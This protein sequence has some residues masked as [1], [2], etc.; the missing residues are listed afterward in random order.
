MIT[1][2]PRLSEILARGREP[3]DL[4]IIGAGP[5]GIS[6]A[7]E[8][9]G[10]GMRVCLLEAGGDGYDAATQSLY[11]GTVVGDRYPPLRDTRFGGLG[12]AT[13]VWAG[14]CRPLDEVDFEGSAHGRGCRW[15][16]GRPELLPYYR[17]AHEY[18]GLGFFD[19]DPDGWQSRFRQ[20]PL[21]GDDDVI[22][23]AIF[24]VL[25]R[26]FGKSF[27]ARLQASRDVE[28]VLDAPVVRLQPSENGSIRGASVQTL[29][30]R[31]LEVAA[32]R[33]VLAAGGIENARMLLL[34][35]DSPERAPGNAHG[36]VGRFFTDHPFVNLGAVTLSGSPRRLDF[37]FPQAVARAG[38]EDA[39]GEDADGEARPAVRATMTFKR[40]LIESE[41][42]QNAALFFHPR[43]E[44]HPYFASAEVKAF[45]ELWD[46]LRHKAVP[47]GLGPYLGRAMRGPH[48]IAYATARKLLVRDGPARQWRVRAMF[49]TESQH[50][51]RV[52]LDSSPD[53]LGRP[54]ARVEWRLSDYDLR[55]MRKWTQLFDARLRQAGV[56][57]LELAFENTAE[58]WRSAVEGGKHH[59]GTTRMHADPRHGVVNPN[60]RVHDSPNL[61]VT[62]SS[63]FPSGG[64][65]NPTLTIVALAI[66]LADHLRAEA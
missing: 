55:C 31:R 43:Y 5:A 28:V 39:D 58:A 33:F 66:R 42:L 40:E 49:E 3:Y 60:G 48:R 62:G 20:P 47:G 21:L 35:G 8:L 38:G 26:R 11:E 59:I 64:Y 29:D 37:Y 10:S 19:Y 57:E 25:P 56:G 1:H 50:D 23:H 13:R 65:A 16:F 34:A 4:C 18:C 44:S 46:K 2:A 12:G 24:H 15:P 7:L 51:N 6:L 54:R 14:W 36:L 45:L 27:R 9:E 32:R 52:T 22:E 63:V 61:Y 17:R 41:G 30:G 53:A